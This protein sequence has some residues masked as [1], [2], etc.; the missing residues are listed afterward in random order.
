MRKK[1][2]LQPMSQSTS[3]LVNWGHYLPSHVGTGKFTKQVSGMIKFPPYQKGIIIG[4][5]LSDAPLR[6]AS[7]TSKNALLVF[8][9]SL[10]HSEYVWFVFNLLSHYCSSSPKLTTGIRSGKRYWGLQF[11]TRS[12]PCIT[13][14]YYLFYLN[15]VKIVPDNIYE[16]LTPVALAHLIMGDGEA[17]AWFKSLY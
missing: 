2:A 15:K 9:Q 4:L 12:M 5:I 3:A 14:L 7:K 6:F 16:L 17:Y 1:K 8:K 13:E 10:S 11:F